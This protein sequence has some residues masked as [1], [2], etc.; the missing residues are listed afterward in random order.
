MGF[1]VV[2]SK[3]KV[4]D[5]NIF[6]RTD[7]WS[8]LFLKMFP[9]SKWAKLNGFE[10]LTSRAFRIRSRILQ[11]MFSFIFTAFF[12]KP[13]K[14]RPV[15]AL[16]SVN[17]YRAKRAIRM[18]H[19]SVTFFPELENRFWDRIWTALGEAHRVVTLVVHLKFIFDFENAKKWL[20]YEDFT[21]IFDRLKFF[22]K[23]YDY[24]G[25]EHP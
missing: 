17:P 6:A 5:G 2:W 23:I 15:R 19:F 14:L 3:K 7:F 1:L 22:L 8:T 9:T 21:R 12:L 16:T 20:F 18:A 25:Y 4:D 24:F 13:K 10:Q 11:P